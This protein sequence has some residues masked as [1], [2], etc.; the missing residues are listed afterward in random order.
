M[1]TKKAGTGDQDK[2]RLLKRIDP[3]LFVCLVISLPSAG[4]SGDFLLEIFHV[5]LFGAKAQA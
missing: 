1:M 2:S 5:L 4:S 3:L